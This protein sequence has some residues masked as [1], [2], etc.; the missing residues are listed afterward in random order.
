MA[1]GHQRGRKPTLVSST[2][3]NVHDNVPS[4]YKLHCCTLCYNYEECII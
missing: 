3:A 1:E 2:I 4:G